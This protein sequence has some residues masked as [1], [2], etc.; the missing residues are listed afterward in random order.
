MKISKRLVL[1]YLKDSLTRLERNDILE[2]QIPKKEH[3][4]NYKFHKSEK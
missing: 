2:L 4:W 3:N 1:K